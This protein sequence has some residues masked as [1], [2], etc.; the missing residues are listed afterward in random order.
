MHWT[1]FNGTSDVTTILPRV[2]QTMSRVTTRCRFRRSANHPIRLVRC[3]FF[4]NVR[5]LRVV[6]SPLV[7]DD[8]ELMR[9]RIA[10]ALRKASQNPIHLSHKKHSYRVSMLQC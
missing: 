7:S 10:A 9:N 5:G 8:P 6:R 2:P 1:I 3:K 4:G